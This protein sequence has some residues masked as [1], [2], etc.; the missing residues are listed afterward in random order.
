MREKVFKKNTGKASLRNCSMDGKF[1]DIDIFDI[2]RFTFNQRKHVFCL[3]VVFLYGFIARVNECA[4][5]VT[6]RDDVGSGSCPRIHG[7]EAA[8]ALTANGRRTIGGSGGSRPSQD[9]PKVLP[10]L[11]RLL[12]GRGPSLTGM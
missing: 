1:A 9:I 4:G 8:A 10:D 7:A 2:H 5:C 11:S 12:L 3:L 6:V